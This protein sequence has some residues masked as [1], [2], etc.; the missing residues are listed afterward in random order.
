MLN[1]IKLICNNSISNFIGSLIAIIL[2]SILMPTIL[3]NKSD[4]FLS[5]DL[6]ANYT[7]NIILFSIITFIASIILVLRIVSLLTPD[8]KEIISESKIESQPNKLN[9]FLSSITENSAFDKAPSKSY[10]I[11]V[12]IFWISVISVI[13]YL[14]STL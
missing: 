5:L 14:V 10:L 3:F 7:K 2:F 13:F 9:K 1:Q 4:T 6:S 12:G 8:E 11:T